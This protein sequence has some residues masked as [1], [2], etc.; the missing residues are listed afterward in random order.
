[1]PTLR[2]DIPS[3]CAA[4]WSSPVARSASPTQ[5]LRSTI[6]KAT[7]S[8]RSATRTTTRV[9]DRGP[10]PGMFSTPSSSGPLRGLV[11]YCRTMKLWMI[12]TRPSENT[13]AWRWL[14]M[15]NLNPRW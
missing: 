4:A 13:S 10:T 1:M 7:T 9:Q 14:P 3:V 12:S 6:V 2:G 11:L 5:L 8:S 15:V